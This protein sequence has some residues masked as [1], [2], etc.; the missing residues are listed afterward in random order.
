MVYLIGAGPGDPGLITYKGLQILKSCDAVIYDRLGTG[1]LLDLVRPDCAKIY[2]GKQ[3]GAHYKKQEEINRILVET[4]GKYENVVRLKGGDSFVFGRGGEEILTLQE[5][6]IPFQ[7]IPGVTSAIAV[8]EVL[9]IPVT[10]RE[11]SRSF[12][13]ITGHTKKGEADALANIHKQEGTSVFLM[14]LSNLEPIMQRLREEG[15]S[16]ETPVSVISNGMLPGETIVRGTVGTIG[17]L[18]SKNELVSPAII[19]VG[20]TAACTMKDKKRSAIDG[21]KIGVV[22]TAVFREKLRGLLEE[23]GASLFSICDM[24]VRTCP[25]MEKLDVAIQ[26]LSDYRWIVFTSQNGIRI[27]FDRVRACAVDLRKFADIRFAVVGSGCAQALEQYG[28][29]ADYI[30]EQYTTESL[31]NGICAVVKS[32]EKVLIPRAKEG[33]PVLEQIL[34]AN[35]IDAEILSIYDVRGARTENWKYLNNYDAILFASASGVHAFADCLAET[36]QPDWNPAQGRKRIVLGTIGQ[37]TAD[38]LIKC[39]LPADVVPEQCDAK[40]LIKALD[41]AFD[42]KKT[43]NN[44]E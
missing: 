30:P 42:M 31:A 35:R 19:V 32:G 26:N 23:K 5:S 36:G 16:E 44:K 21:C 8:P 40:N 28:F 6:D 37:V 22:G 4:A 33:S 20:Q 17:K 11:M 14:G 25:D 39:G 27:F 2:V 7:V 29:Y 18:V 38:A 34:S 41:I 12:H 1:E 13:V 10:H 24:H 15:E 3:A 43:D 9:G